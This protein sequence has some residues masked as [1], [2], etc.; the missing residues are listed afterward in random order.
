MAVSGSQPASG[1]ILVVSGILESELEGFVDEKGWEK[2]KR[3]I[4]EKL[5]KRVR[6]ETRVKEATHCIL[7]QQ[8]LK[9]RSDKFVSILQNLEKWCKVVDIL[10]VFLV[11]LRNAESQKERV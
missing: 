9:C 8:T 3:L 2:D 6:L 7:I 1:V 11:M 4:C 10:M 5:G